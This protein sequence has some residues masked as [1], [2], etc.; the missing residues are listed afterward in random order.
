MAS[1]G[2]FA[3]MNPLHKTSN[4]VVYSNGNLTT[5]PTSSWSSTTYC[6]STMVIPKDKKIY[7]ECRLDVQSGQY[8]MVGVAT[9]L[10]NPSGTTVGGDGSVTLYAS[11]KYVNGSN[12]NTGLGESSAGDILQVAIDG[13]NN[14]VWLGFN[15][16]WG[17]SGDPSNGT[18][19]SGTINTSSS[20]GYDIFIVTTQNLN[21]TITMNFGQDDTFGGSISSSGNTCANGGAFKYTP[22]TGF[23]CLSSKSLSVSDDIDPAQTDDDY[24]SKQFNVV[25]Y[26]GDGSSSNAITGL[27]FQPDLVWTKQRSTNEAFSNG[28]VDSS[29]GRSKSMHSSRTDAE[30]TSSSSQDL[31]SFDSDGFTVGTDSNININQNSTTNVAWCWRANGGTTASNSDG[32]TTTTVQAN[33]KSGFSIVE[34]PNYSGTTTL[35]HGLSKAPE[36]IIVK[37]RASS[38]Q[39]IVQH[40]SLAATQIIKLNSYD[41]A[42]TD[43]AFNDTAPTSSVFSLGSGFAGSGTAIAYC[44]HSVEGSS[45]FGSYEGNGNADGAF[46]YTG[47]RPRM[48]F[49][50]DAD[51]GENWQ[52]FDSARNTFNPVDIGLMWNSSSAESTG[53][54]SGFDVD[55]LSN[56]FKM[57]CSHDNLNGSS[58]YIY[59]AWGDVPFKYNNTF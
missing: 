11:Q 25:T 26:T 46:I 39:W 56:G 17:N 35:G 29:R 21:G 12:S 10:G 15:N 41:S 45:K 3:T 36:F 27:G 50:K 52:T 57:R 20:L 28:L 30:N 1:S 54:G 44:W 58:T 33:T 43:D 55:F 2:N 7:V 13:S 48:L 8:A 59:G 53:S 49:V 24:P 9:N 4:N 37:L 23:V 6:R 51:R 22:P 19:E 18:N 16:T 40:T 31:V 34:I 14:K 42:S 47:F 38:S 32:A 5:S